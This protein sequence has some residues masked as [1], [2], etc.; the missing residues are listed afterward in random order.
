[1]GQQPAGD[2]TVT[3]RAVRGVAWTLPMSLFSRAIGL[4]GT[5]ILA[6]FLAPAEYGEVSAAVIVVSTVNSVTSFGVGL[7]LVTNRNVGRAEAFHATALFLAIGAVVL[8]A[9]W[10]LAW[11]VGPW[12]GAPDLQRYVHWLVVGA[13]LDRLAYVPERMAVRELRFRWIS[14]CRAG[15][16]ITYTGFSVGLAAAGLGGMAILWGN[17]ARSVFRAVTMIPAAGW[18]EWA[19]PHRLRLAKIAEVVR[20]GANVTATSAASFAMRRFDN[21]LV[22]A[23]FGPAAMGAY[24][25]A[26]NLADTPA[27]AIGEQITDV[28]TASFPH[29][30]GEQR[31]AALRRSS[32]MTSAIM[33]PLAIGLAAVAP[34][35]VATFFDARWA[36]VGQML[37]L[38]SAISVARPTALVVVGYLYAGQRRAEVLWLEVASLAAIIVSIATVGRLGLAWACGAVGAVFV[39]RTLAAMW[40]VHRTDGIRMSSLLAPLAAPFAGSLAMAGSVVAVRTL[41]QGVAPGPRLVLEILV[42]AA[43]YLGGALLLF[44]SLVRDFVTLA[45]SALSRSSS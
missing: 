35:L 38:L 23:Y 41:L 22:S 20:F 25:Y 37:V 30:E 40:I 9:T 13:V 28:V 17:V 34:T 15:A 4:V 1:M 36:S 21:L 11:H 24:N 42:G 6:R 43:V 18:R 8:G 45:R 7:Y 2:L 33:F 10:A 3:K 12:L 27:V 44:P 31:A 26:Y 39:L 29:L 14:M 32:T 5:L 16:E 19:E